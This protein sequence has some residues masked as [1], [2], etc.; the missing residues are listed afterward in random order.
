M[1]LRS[2]PIRLIGLRSSVH[3]HTV[4]R[5]GAFPHGGIRGGGLAKLEVHMYCKCKERIS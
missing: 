1:I 5:G 2:F 3:W 4:R